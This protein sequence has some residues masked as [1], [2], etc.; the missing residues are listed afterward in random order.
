[1]KAAV[2]SKYGLPGDLSIKELDIPTPKDDELLIRVH[3]TSVN[4]NDCYVLLGRP[5]AMQ[6]FTGLFKARTSIIGTDYAGQIEVVESAVNS[7][8]AGDKIMGF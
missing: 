7:F 1:M 6:L 4:R 8:N 3:S 5:F 2:R